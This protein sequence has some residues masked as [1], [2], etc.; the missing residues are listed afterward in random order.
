M[1]WYLLPPA[2]T[3]APSLLSRLLSK[4]AAKVSPPPGTLL[5]TLGSR[6]SKAPPAMAVASKHS[7]PAAKYPKAAAPTTGPIPVAELLGVI[8]EAAK[9]G[10]G[11]GFDSFAHFLSHFLPGL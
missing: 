4:V 3:S 5:Y 11:V 6:S 1:A 2:P 8:Y 7:A 9:A 10:A